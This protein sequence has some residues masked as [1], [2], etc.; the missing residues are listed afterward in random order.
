MR[1][2]SV[3]RLTEAI[4][5]AV[6][7]ANTVMTPDI[8]ARLQAGLSDEAT[9]VARAV[10]SDL[11]ENAAIA[12]AE[13]VPMCQDTGMVVVYLTFG[14]DVRWL[15]GSVEEAINEGVRRGYRDGYL[16]FSVVADPL[17]RANTRD[18]TPAII[19][20]R[21]VP[22]EDVRVDILPKGFGA[23]NRSRLTMLKP[24]DGQAGVERF[25]LE[26]VKIAG[27][28]ACPPF[29]VGVGIGGDF[30]RVAELA[31][32]A[33]LEPLDQPNSDPLLAEME[34]RLSATI[35]DMGIGPQ[36]FGGRTT[37]LG[38]RIKVGAT[39]I[40]GLPVAVNM[41]CHSTRHLSFPI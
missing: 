39:H 16:R 14:Q 18:N 29:I 15:D 13:H 8:E 33:L 9:P 26:T 40:A 4:S 3:Q 25:I 35:N 20:Y 28:Q 7:L 19:H 21:L 6:I 22:G 17:R 31:K 37:L 41:S 2:V 23:E 36:G 32:E 10:I 24:S 5:E 1:E 12:R 38:L 30:E 34:A 11:L 27:P